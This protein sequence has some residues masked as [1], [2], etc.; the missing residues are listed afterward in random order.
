MHIQ[1]SIVALGQWHQLQSPALIDDQWS[2]D[3]GHTGVCVCVCCTARRSHQSKMYVNLDIQKTQLLFGCTVKVKTPD[4]E[5]SYVDR[6][7]KSSN[8]A[9][10]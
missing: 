6:H 10:N 4:Q 8:I 7:L 3:G 9:Y 1:S 5:K 2:V